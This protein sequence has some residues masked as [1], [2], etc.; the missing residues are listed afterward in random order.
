M[1]KREIIK[2]LGNPK[3]EG[4]WTDENYPIWAVG[5]EIAVWE[6]GGNPIYLRFHHEDREVGIDVT[7][8]TP[9]SPSSNHDG[10]SI[11]EELRKHVDN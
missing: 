1:R 8:L 9:L 10:K 4:C 5:H 11:Y 7:L 6:N 3:Y 2:T